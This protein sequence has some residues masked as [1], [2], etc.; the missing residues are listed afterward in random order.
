MDKDL[1]KGLSCKQCLDED[2]K[3]MEEN[4]KEREEHRH[5]KEE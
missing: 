2:F 3:Q 5:Q 4:E 1:F